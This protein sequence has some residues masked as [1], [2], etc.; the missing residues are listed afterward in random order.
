[1]KIHLAFLLLVWLAPLLPARAEETNAPTPREI[2]SA[3][4][5]RIA[6]VI[7]PTPGTAPQTFSAS[8]IITEAGGLP[9][10]LVGQKA[11]LAFQA[12]DRLLLS[13]TI[14]EKPFALGRDGQELWVHTPAKKFGVVG[15]PGRPLF[16][17]APEKKD[18]SEL[19]PFKLPI[20]KE[21]LLLVPV[22]AKIKLHPPETIDGVRCQVISGAPPPEAVK[23]FRL[24]PF[25]IGVAI[26]E[27]DHLPARIKFN[28][29]RGLSLR[30]QLS[31]VKLTEAWPAAR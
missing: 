1:M 9:K 20:L 16:F 15:T 18:L 30:V 11:R 6:E 4:L 26:R 7:E 29:G 28:S 27:T 3:A 17:T 22:L 2:F 5:L 14:E 10:N 21:Q 23:A 19:P 8:V 24:L 31:D 13:T 12:P 25:S